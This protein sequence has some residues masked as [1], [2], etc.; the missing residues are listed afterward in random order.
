[1]SDLPDKQD[2]APRQSGRWQVPLLVFSICFI[3]F[4]IWRMNQPPKEPPFDKL[5][6]R[7]V[8][9]K[10]A[11]FYPETRRYIEYFLASPRRTPQQSRYLHRLIAEVIFDQESGNTIHAEESALKI[12][13]HSDQGLPEG[14]THDGRM[15]WMRS[16]AW[17]WLRQPGQALAECQLAVDKGIDNIWEGRKRIIEIKRTVGGM[18]VE[19]FH[20]AYREFLVNGG[21]SDDLRYWAVE[22]KIELYLR[23][24]R[25]DEAQRF[26]AGNIE[27]FYE[28]AQKD[29]CDYLQALVWFHVKRLDEAEGLLR[30]LLERTEPADELYART[31]WLLGRILQA[32]NKLERALACYADVA[33][34]TTAGAYR[35]ASMFRQA[36]LLASLGRH[37]QSVKAFTEVVRFTREDA[38]DS[39]IDLS[40]IRKSTT[41]E[42]QK[43]F[44]EGKLAEALEYLK[45]A[46]Q[47]VPSGHAQLQAVYAERLA[48]L[49][50]A[51]GRSGPAEEVTDDPVIGKQSRHY[52][53]RAGA[54]Y[55]RLAKLL[56]LDEAASFEAVRRAADAFDMAGEQ[57]RTIEILEAFVEDQ[58]QGRR[59]A[60]VLHRLGGMYQ[61]LGEYTRA[62]EIYRRNLNGFG[63]TSSTCLSIVPLADC[64]MSTN[65]FEKAEQVLLRVVEPSP[66]PDGSSDPLWP[67]GDVYKR[68]L[69]RLS[70]LYRQTGDYEKAV[71]GYEE[72]LER[73]GGEPRAVRITFRLADVYRKSSAH[74]LE[75]LND[76]PYAAGK[77]KLEDLRGQRLEKAGRLFDEVIGLYNSRAER[78]LDQLDRLYV[79]LSHFYRADVRFDLLLG[80]GCSDG[81]LIEQALKLY[82]RAAWMYRQDPMVMSACVQMVNCYLQVDRRDE[83]RST[84]YWARSVLADIPDAQFMQ[85]SPKQDRSWWMDYL[86]WLEGTLVFDGS[87]PRDATRGFG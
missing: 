43:L 14:K 71:V 15:H 11:G 62:I 63:V 44:A 31:G 68:A 59:T 18:A 29:R 86:R 42:Y 83:A 35:T 57:Q 54:E 30:R 28:S 73:F 48:D 12:I 27:T 23:E 4:S 79:K 26:L 45:I 80:S 87:V 40:A 61:N 39:K 65:D 81:A 64:L 22:Q 41:L 33:A 24:S 17:Q 3:I 53:S 51:L 50:F 20:E 13:E 70:D 32:D 56:M 16:F 58:P 2:S 60:D 10:K 1:M 38:Y 85:Y 8:S 69:L 67:D 6:A 72:A 34:Q 66:G 25:H 82:E 49:Y 21:V 46:A 75:S 55:L 5:Y 78:S 76:C 37:R 36:E 84:L 52:L 7:L 77:Q 74:L 47:L 9:L 19:H